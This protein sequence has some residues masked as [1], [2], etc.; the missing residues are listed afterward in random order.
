MY[1]TSI[2]VYN[3]YPQIHS[4]HKLRNINISIHQKKKKK[5]EKKRKE[6]RKRK[7]KEKKYLWKDF[8][9][10]IDKVGLVL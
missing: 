1:Q 6:K 5:K 3:E 8:F 9:E 4:I 7:K 10:I 2:F